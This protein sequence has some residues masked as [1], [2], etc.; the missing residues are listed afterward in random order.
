MKR[1]TKIFQFEFVENIPRPVEQGILYISMPYATAIHSCACG[2]GYEVVTK[3]SPQRWQL[4]FDGETISLY[5][6]IGNWDLP[7]RSHYWI[8]NSQIH[9]A[10]EWSDR[11]VEKERKKANN[12]KVFRKPG[13]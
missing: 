12:S 4:I 11:K 10:E 1:P 13:I 2:C 9:W 3:L 6:S 8:T 7:C 5:P